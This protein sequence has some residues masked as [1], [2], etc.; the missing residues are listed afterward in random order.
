[1]VT[2]S[3]LENV[4]MTST[5]KRE[6]KIKRLKEN[7]KRQRQIIQCS[8]GS[9]LRWHRMLAVNL[10]K[11]MMSMM[12]IIRIKMYHNMMYIGRDIVGLGLNR[13]CGLMQN[14]PRY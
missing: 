11:M 14:S 8:K 7:T 4:T 9:E 6:V 13:V 5:R 10:V 3:S 12:M 1:M 2:R